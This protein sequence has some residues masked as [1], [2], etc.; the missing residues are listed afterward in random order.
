MEK[1]RV[2]KL[3]RLQKIIPYNFKKLSLLNQAFTHTSYANENQD[4]EYLDNERL[5]FLGDAV[6]DLVISHLLMD[7][8]PNYTEGDLTKLRSAIVN[9]KRFADLAREL[10]LGEYLLLGRG[11]DHT[12]GRDKNSILADT[13]E[14]LIAAIYLDRGYKSVFKVIK[15]HF[16]DIL[17]AAQNGDL[18]HGDF[19]SKLQEYAQSVFR[20]TPQYI[21]VN[22][23]GP[24]HNKSFEVNVILNNKV[25]GTGFGKSKKDSEQNAAREALKK[26]SEKAIKQS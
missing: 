17:T 21:S 10:N 16:S 7:A 25:W 23:S 3:K 20:S 15:R 14:A 18:Y 13:Y 4:Q 8:F 2:Q 26:L 9:E 12:K 5:E 24:D 11:E 6:I 19:K 1:E 22:E